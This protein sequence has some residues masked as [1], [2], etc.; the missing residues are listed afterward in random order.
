M[1]GERFELEGGELKSQ[2]ATREA[3]EEQGLNFTEIS[4]EEDSDDVF[5]IEEIPQGE[6]WN[7]GFVLAP[8]GIMTLRRTD[9]YRVS[10]TGDIDLPF[11]LKYAVNTS[12][13]YFFYQFRYEVETYMYEE[14]IT[15]RLV[16]L[17]LKTR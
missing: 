5:Y 16:S 11:L 15:R 6:K 8:H 14:E 7:T 1:T 17:V 4:L 2:E 3:L 12:N 10:F 9:G 13:G